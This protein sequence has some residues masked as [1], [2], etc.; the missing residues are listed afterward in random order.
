M[1]MPQVV[2]SDS[3]DAGSLDIPFKSVLVVSLRD[4]TITA[5][6]ERGCNFVFVLVLQIGIYLLRHDIG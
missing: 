3:L 6:E 5:E 4:R 1:R 2:D